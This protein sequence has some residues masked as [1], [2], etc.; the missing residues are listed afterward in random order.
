MKKN[1]D[2]S[3]LIFGSGGH[4]KVILDI[5]LASKKKVKGFIDDD[6]NKLGMTVLGFK[7]L[8][9]SAFLASNKVEPFSIVLGI[10]NN[11]VRAKVFEKLS[12]LGFA[13]VSAIHPLAIVSPDV[14]IGKGVVIMPG[15][16][17]NAGTVI[18]DGV[19][20]NTACSVDHDCHLGRFCQ[21][22]PGAHLAGKVEVG[23]YSYIGTG[24]SVIQNL[25]IGNS[26]L[27]GAGAAVVNDLPSNVVAVGVPAKIIKKNN[28]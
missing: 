4:G 25:K 15:A 26:C 17:V 1:K 9:D 19:V 24:A 28:G 27:I 20:V 12:K 10:G 6:K 16:V 8:G 7:I 13:I 3:I 22:W 5:L 21:I 2:E 14:K 23:E 11:A 18:E